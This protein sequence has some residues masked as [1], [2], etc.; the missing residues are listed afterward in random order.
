MKRMF[1]LLAAVLAVL[2]L[3][4]C[5]LLASILSGRFTHSGEEIRTMDEIA[6]H[7]PDMDAIEA[8]Y[9]KT[10]A[11]HTDGTGVRKLTQE[12]EECYRL[13][14]DFYTMDTLAELRYYHDMSDDYYA[15]EAAWCLEQQ[16]A[17]DRLFDELLIASAN[18]EQSDELEDFWGEDML[19]SYAGT[20]ETS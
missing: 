16:T 2:T 11:M 6:Y 17:M 20:S 7:R 9:D 8:Q 14:Q 12:L 3:S 15:E 5:S 4:G 10:I 13:Y 19:A 18:C 1:R